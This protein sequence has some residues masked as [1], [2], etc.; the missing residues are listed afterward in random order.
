[1][2]IDR[3]ALP[4]R[5]PRLPHSRYAT[6]F[7]RSTGDDCS[8]ADGSK[9]TAAEEPDSSEGGNSLCQST[10]AAGSFQP[11]DFLDDAVAEMTDSAAKLAA[12]Q[13]WDA[14]PM[15]S[16]WSSVLKACGTDAEAVVKGTQVTSACSQVV[17][18]TNLKIAFETTIPCQQ[19]AVDTLAGS[20]QLKQTFLADA[21]FPLSSDGR[22]STLN[23]ENESGGCT[24]LA[25]TAG[26][27]TSPSSSGTT[28]PSSSGTTTPSSS[29]P[30]GSPSPTPTAGA[31]AVFSTLSMATIA[32]VLRL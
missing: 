16:C 2:G 27:A 25:G 3:R 13:Y 14:E 4:F 20:D 32:L 1:M 29:T 5:A 12:K 23:V 24:G 15:D 28:I 6:R 22:I 19:S 26:V 31:D 8:C 21:S 18:G 9:C 11:V 7:A 30:P 17:A 10:S